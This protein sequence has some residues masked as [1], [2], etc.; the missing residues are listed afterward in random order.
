[1]QHSV[2]ALF[3]TALKY[4]LAQ[5]SSLRR[6]FNRQCLTPVILFGLGLI[7]TLCL[8]S[9]AFA[10][11]IQLSPDRFGHLIQSDVPNCGAVACGPTAAVNSFVF[12]ENQYPSIYDHLLV[13][14]TNGNRIVDYAE[15]VSTAS[16]LSGPQY[17]NTTFPSGTFSD[18]FISGQ[19]GW[20][21]T[22]APGRTIYNQF[23]PNVPLLAAELTDHEDVELLIGFYNS[24]G[25]RTGGHYITVTGLSWT[26]ANH[27]NI[28]DLSD[29]ATIAFIDPG[30]GSNTVS[31]LFQ[32]SPDALFQMGYGGGAKI[33]IG[34]SVSPIPEPSTWLLFVSGLFVLVSLKKR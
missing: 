12:L 25:S 1:M 8:A 29:A 23:N 22:Q 19:Q 6:P 15:M 4:G 30:N 11:N 33:E 24:Q 2:S 9:Q 14:D 32:A 21:E 5:R 26:D 17:M 20:I 27:N 34:F 3:F 31:S 10:F 16:I 7:L 18:R 13:P 28:V